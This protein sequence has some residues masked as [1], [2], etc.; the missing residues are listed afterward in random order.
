M[1]T[2]TGRL[3]ITVTSAQL[4]HET[5]VFKMDP[6]ISLK[7]S[8]QHATSKVISKG[9]SNPVYNESFWFNINSCFRIDGRNLEIKVMDKN[10]VGSDKQIGFGIVDLDPI[11]NF[12]KPK[13]AFR[14]FLNY[15]S[16]PAGLVNLVAEFHE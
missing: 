4:T 3:K 10:K 8:N 5:S 15:H 13:E 11:V 7:L 1:N 2:V 9:G 6:Y 14:C 12:K 16:K